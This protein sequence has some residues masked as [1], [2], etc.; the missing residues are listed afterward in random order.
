[1]EFDPNDPLAILRIDKSQIMAQAKEF[2]SKKWVW[3]PDPKEGYK[4]AEVKSTKGDNFL[5]ETNDGQEVEINKN[6]TEQMNPPKYEKTE[7]MSNL[8]YLNEASVV[9]NLKQ[10][11]F[12]GLIYTYSG[13]F[14]VAINPYR[15]L[16]IYTDKI[17][18]AYRGKRKTEA[19]PHVF[20]ICDNAY[21]NML[22]DR[23]NQ[24]MLITGESGAGKT[25]NTKK[26]IQYLAHVSGGI[27][28]ADEE[29]KKQTGGSLEDQVI[30][31]NPILEA[32]GNAK[33]IRNNN[34]S[35]F[36]KFIR[37][38]FGPQGKLA[39][40]DIESYLLEKSR[41]IYQQEIERNYH[42]FYQILYGAPKDLHDQLLL[43]SNKTADYAY[44]AKGCERA[45][46][47]DD[48]EEWANTELAADTL[49]FSAEEK[50]SM[51][52]ICAACLHWGN[53]KFKQRPREEQAEVADP[54]DLDK[55]SFLMKLPGA[56]F[57]K[58]IVKPRIKVGREYVNQ[59]RNLQQVNYSIGALTKSLYE[60]MF[61][62]LVDRANQ[63][64]MTK[65][66]RAFFIGVLD[67]AGFEIFQFNSFEQLCINVTNEKLQQFFNHHMFILEQ[68]E[69]KREG[70]HWEFIDFGHDLEPTINLI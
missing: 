62:W 33:T 4:A 38:H 68:E 17:V 7:D 46:G 20:C 19:P 25:E 67:I 10:R 3:I 21:Q 15:R 70:I 12:S 55:T 60:R 50:L 51:Y 49:G 52:K 2:E 56:D 8:T 41:V 18:F 26:V 32:Y 34:S 11:Y 9:H 69:Y 30:Q 43:E 36:G 54:K 45:D 65:D 40:A 42:I 61:L 5:V 1:M 29:H 66:R 13:L 63:T 16:P 37:C 27:S 23:E 24:S 44:T 31:T 14:C 28:K 64:L 57:V 48:V 22:Q 59:G 58:N 35:R 6:D 39:G 53:S 47:I